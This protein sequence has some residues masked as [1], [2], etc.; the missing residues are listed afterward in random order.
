MNILMKVFFFFVFSGGGHGH[1]CGG[2]LPTGD[3]FYYQRSLGGTK[4][5]KFSLITKKIVKFFN[6]FET[7]NFLLKIS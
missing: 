2:H 7:M 5:L 4:L 3:L 6:N 1:C